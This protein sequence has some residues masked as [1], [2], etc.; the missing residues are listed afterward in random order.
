MQNDDID[1]PCFVD[2]NRFL[3]SD[4]YKRKPSSVLRHIVGVY[5]YICM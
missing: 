2:R 1:L 4:K 5:M 3:F